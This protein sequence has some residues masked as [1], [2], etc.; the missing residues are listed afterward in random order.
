[1]AITL[2]EIYILVVSV[3]FMMTAH[4]F[5][6]FLQLAKLDTT[7]GSCC[8]QLLQVNLTII[9]YNCNNTYH[10]SDRRQ[11]NSLMIIQK[12]GHIKRNHP[13]NRLMILIKGD[14]DKT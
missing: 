5:G 6:H 11:L 8:F 3:Y 12:G 4:I 14:T 1:M 10:K 2:P 9:V 7:T 13:K